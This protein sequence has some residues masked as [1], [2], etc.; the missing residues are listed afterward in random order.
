MQSIGGDISPISEVPVGQIS[1]FWTEDMNP[2]L[3]KMYLQ[4][5][6]N[7]QIGTFL[8]TEGQID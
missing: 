5:I 7:F 6:Q 1:W 2:N 8:K 4:A 3:L